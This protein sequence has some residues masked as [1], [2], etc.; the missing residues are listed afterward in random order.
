MLILV[1]CLISS[2]AL[3]TCFKSVF[4]FSSVR[5]RALAL[6]AT[7][8]EKEDAV[9]QFCVGTNT[10]FKSWVIKPV[11]DFSELVPAKGGLNFLEKI[12]SPPQSPG[13]PRPVTLTIAASVPTAL[14]WYGWYKVD[15]LS[16]LPPLIHS[17]FIS[18]S[19]D[20]TR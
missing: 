15:D 16:F 11:R 20:G 2:F 3:S 14:V 13:L 4:F 17:L 1:L 10:F 19:I 18:L 5:Q 12:T 7:V 8:Q 6:H 9:S